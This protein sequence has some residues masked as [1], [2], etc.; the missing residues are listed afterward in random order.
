MQLRSSAQPIDV[1]TANISDHQPLL[2][3]D[4]LFWNVMMQGKKRQGRTGVNYNNGF[5]LIETDEQYIER[6]YKIAEV[7]ADIIYRHPSIFVIS[8]CE[9]PIQ[10]LHVSALL[11]SF[12]NYRCMNK[13]F[14]DT[15]EYALHQPCLA[16]Y[17]RWGLLNLVDKRY[18]VN[19]VA[20]DFIEHPMLFAK[21][22]N[23]FQLWQLSKA[24]L[25]PKFPIV[26]ISLVPSWN[27]WAL[28]NN[29]LFQ[30]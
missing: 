7:I 25:W 24:R 30:L 8:L 1:I 28:K 14:T 5:A 4:V 6:L 13:F 22:A 29:H 23:R 15:V 27:N 12:K 11:Q 17:P 3:Q 10:P 20:C 16:G 21:L 18:Q 19:E 26:W 2:H 9:G